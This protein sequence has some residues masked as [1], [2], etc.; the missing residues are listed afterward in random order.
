[1]RSIWIR[2]MKKE[3]I[4]KQATESLEF[5]DVAPALA[6]AL[7]K[8]DLSAPVWLDKHQR[9]MEKFQMTSF[10]PDD[11]LEPVAFD[12]MD[13]SILDDDEVPRGRR[14]PRNDF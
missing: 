10:K 7:E 12:R 1:M 11:F 3:R 14:D 9:D 5:D 4:A 8:M 13:L 6:V 2:L